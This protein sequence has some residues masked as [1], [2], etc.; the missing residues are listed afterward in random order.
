MDYLQEYDAYIPAV[1]AQEEIELFKEY[2]AR[3]DNLKGNYLRLI[4]QGWWLTKYYYKGTP[5][6][7]KCILRLATAKIGLLQYCDECKDK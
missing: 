6:C 3:L 4:L 7:V 1:A 5:L 2:V